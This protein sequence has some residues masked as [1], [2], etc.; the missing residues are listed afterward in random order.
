[1]AETR[2]VKLSEPV[3][4]GDKTLTE[5]E[6][7]RANIGDEEDA[8]QRCIDMKRSKNPLCL[9][10]CLFSRLTKIPYDKLRQMHNDDYGKI[11]EA[12]NE[13]NGV[14]EPK[15]DDENPMMPELN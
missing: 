12:A 5:V 7:R 4:V 8:L 10:L 15:K 1:M 11:R 3:E 2:I 9:E 6:V 13:L 14:P